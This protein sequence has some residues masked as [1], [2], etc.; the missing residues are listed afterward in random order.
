MPAFTYRHIKDLYPKFWSKSVEVVKAISAEI[1]LQAPSTNEEKQASPV[2]VVKVTDWLTRVTLDIIGDTGMG[3]E[4]NT[5]KD[6]NNKLA[7]TYR[8]LFAPSRQAKI[9][10]MLS[11]FLGETF[12]HLLPVKRNG[13]ILKSSRTIRGAS[14]E[15]IKRRQKT[16]NETGKLAEKDIISVAL[17]SGG[18]SEDNLVDQVMTFLV[19]GHETTSTA[20]AWALVA[21]SRHPDIQIRLRNDIR[22]TLPAID[23]ADTPLTAELIDSIPYL[24][25]VCNEVLRV[26]P[27]VLMTK[28]V[29]AINTTILDQ[30]VPKGTEILISPCAINL[31]T[32]Q[33]GPDAAEF[34]PERWMGPGRANSGGAESNFSLLTFLH[35]L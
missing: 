10:A 5:I 20:M 12:V 29:A 25:A 24:H 1:G 23:D 32:E 13:D 4:F 19:A 8:E 33:W 21:L 3:Y 6:P 30:P 17:Q 15:L 2:A 7:V 28:R 22:A 31:S 14:R 26:Y 35:G 11:L 9:I 16:L 27:P 18:I 34:K